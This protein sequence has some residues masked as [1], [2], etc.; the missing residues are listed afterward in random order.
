M[1]N[2]SPDQTSALLNAVVESL[3]FRVWAC[4]NTG[5]V[6]LQ[7][8]VSIRDF[9]N[10]VGESP[11]KL[12][13]PNEAFQR[14][15][16]AAERAFAGEVAWDEA[17]QV[18]HGEER[19][20][21]YV[22][23]PIRDGGALR[24]IVGVDLDITDL[25]RTQAALIESEER[26]RSIMENAPDVMLQVSVDGT[27]TYVNFAVPP[28]TKADI[29]GTKAETWVP[30]PFRPRVREALEQVFV[31]GRRSSYE[32]QSGV[33]GGEPAWYSVVA[34]PI[35]VGGQVVSAILV[36]RDITQERRAAEALRESESLYRLLAENSSDV[37]SRH[38]PTGEWLYLSPAC[39]SLLGYEPDELVGK[40]P[41][42][43][44]HPDDRGRV[45]ASLA[46]LV[47]TGLTQSLTFR[48]RRKDGAYIWSET[49]GRP[50]VHAQTGELLEVVATSRDVTSRIEAT[51]KLRQREAELAHADRLS[52]MGQMASEVAHEL[53]Q[54]L[55]AISN[56]A[57]ACLTLVGQQE[58]PDENLRRW[59][60]QIAGQARRA[61]D[62]LRRITEFVRKGELDAS[63]VNLNDLVRD[64]LGMLE[65]ELNRHSIE[66]VTDLAAD[67]PLV[68]AD[69]LLIEQVL[70]NLVRNAVD[71]L[72]D[73]PRHSRRI[74]VRTAPE[75]GGL[76]VQVSDVGGGLPPEHLERLF[77]PYFTTKP[78]G[79]G[80]GLPICRSTVEAHGGR[81]RA[82]NNE[83]G[84]ATF[85][86]FLPADSHST[87]SA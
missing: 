63:E 79:T 42:G 3:P 30:E 11:A 24:G 36:A 34:G 62:V 18:V 22:M 51:Q 58:A 56:F 65:F 87:G 61:G 28:A 72:A 13:V 10:V 35:T 82:Q 57:D 47:S 84:G 60:E 20:Y 7:N 12:A 1:A 67:L 31:H 41:F 40:N 83:Q 70:V 26:I 80:M 29:L 46:N 8:S 16:A 68:W 76:I 81:I 43:H 59:L 86:F 15:Q 54:P 33:V 53:N 52:T 50:V 78:G 19:H 85:E 2:A 38:K 39:K 32:T 44:I 55:Y 4:D 14:M 6:I 37:I 74:V 23:A 48:V 49:H 9:G 77:E 45:Q 64:I 5:R 25:R 66:V 21:R 71:A 73:V 27:I 17:S 69:R 75:P